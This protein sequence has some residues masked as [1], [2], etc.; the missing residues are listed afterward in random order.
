[1]W[2]EKGTRQSA[3]SQS[4]GTTISAKGGDV[5]LDA[6]RDITGEAAQLNARD[7]L[8]LAAKGKVDLGAAIDS[9]GAQTYNKSGGGMTYHS[10]QAS[11]QDQT[12]NRSTLN[13]QDVKIKSGGDT[14]LSAVTVNADTLDIDA[15][16]KLILPAVTTQDSEGWNATDGNSASVS[17]NG[18]GRSDETLNYTQFN[19]KGTS[20][21]KAQGIQAQ[22]GEN[23]NLQDLAQQPG[24]GWVSQITS[25]PNLA[26]SV[27]WQ[28]VKEA[29]EQWAYHQNSMGPVSA[30][31][32]AVMVAAAA[33]PAA[34]AA[35][36]A[37]GNTAAVAAGE[38]VSLG[39]S[40]VFL[41]ATGTTISTAVGG[42]VQ[43]GVLALSS[44][45]GTSFFNNDGDLG[46]VFKELG[47]SDSVKNLAAAIVTGGV[48]AG[49]GFNA[50][51]EPN[52]GAGQAGMGDQLI[53]NLKIQGTSTLINTTIKGGSFEDGLKSALINALVNTVAASTA[54]T[55]GD[56]S[57][58]P[59]AVFND[60]GN[61]LAHFMAG[62]AG[63]ALNA[64]N[65]GGCAAGAIGA[66]LGELM[67][68]GMKGSPAMDAFYSD[69]DK[70]YL[71][72]LVGGLGAAL[73]GGDAQQIATA[74][75]AASNA[76]A[77][78]RLAHYDER[79]QMRLAAE[80]DK[81]LEARLNRAACLEIK[82]WAQYPE[83]SELYKENYVS[84]VEASTLVSELAWVQQQ[85]QFG[86]FKYSVVDKV[87]D[88]IAAATGLA[89][90][91]FNGRAVGGAGSLD[92]C[93]V[94]VCAD[95]VAGIPHGAN[96][97]P[98]GTYTFGLSGAAPLLGTVRWAVGV[99]NERGILDFGTMISTPI[100]GVG[101]SNLYLNK[102]G[103]DM[104]YQSGT[105]ASNNG[106]ISESFRGGW[107]IL[108]AGLDRD[109]TGLSG[110]SINFGPQY[111]FEIGPQETRTWSINRGKK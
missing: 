108:G 10:L 67:A 31:L 49:M 99:S 14:R 76:A 83:G 88:E 37:A 20:S 35:G 22:V 39:S 19:I 28:R 59:N 82:C 58:G 69:Q 74:N 70:V 4:T 96:G 52:V 41:S 81:A 7:T 100:L 53:S 9:E 40:G 95:Q 107:G 89:S 51:G 78:N 77:N 110:F 80:G 13:A 64:G 2:S 23:V 61:K 1:R 71:S 18:K 36:T 42:A 5:S 84:A 62:C 85:K 29:H 60:V 86:Y 57:N 97:I 103:V 15:K 26:G 72:G 90:G 16:G 43:A 68:E 106:S 101:V 73:A 66:T 55:I 33:A 56:L 34:G 25:D 27:E 54:N 12:L 46:K 32:V 38:G 17:A 102:W 30:A 3:T 63:G 75:W 91:T 21:I 6:G 8:S 105:F 50:L 47:Q 94:G 87:S 104:S 79:E 11:S 92:G 93:R 109:E 45:V 48:L 65:S 24:M 44:Q 111:G 98:D